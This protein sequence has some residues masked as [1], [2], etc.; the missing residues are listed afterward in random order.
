MPLKIESHWT[1]EKTCWGKINVH[2][3]ALQ[4][5]TEGIV[6]VSFNITCDAKESA[7]PCQT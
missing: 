5:N 6:S 2:K 3:A 1:E 4:S 7:K